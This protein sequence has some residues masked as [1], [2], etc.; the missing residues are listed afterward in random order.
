MKIFI[1]S[2]LMLTCIS[3]CHKEREKDKDYIESQRVREQYYDVICGKWYVSDAENNLWRTQ[4]YEFLRNGAF[5]GYIDFCNSDYIVN[6]PESHDTIKGQWDIAYKSSLESIVIEIATTTSPGTKNGYLLR[7]KD[8][9]DSVLEMQ[10]MATW[11]MRSFR[12]R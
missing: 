5:M 3:A 7:F 12:K 9:N 10:E 2:L 11:E 6:N 4:E 1:V 8:V